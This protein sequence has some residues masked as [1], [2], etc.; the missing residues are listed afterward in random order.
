[1]R[2]RGHEPVVGRP[3]GGVAGD[4][5]NVTWICPSCGF[6]NEG[7]PRCGSCGRGEPD[8]GSRHAMLAQVMN[9]NYGTVNNVYMS[10]VEVVDVREVQAALNV[11][12]PDT[13]GVPALPPAQDIPTL[14]PAPHPVVRAIN[15]IS[16]T[17]LL[18]FIVAVVSAY[19]YV[20]L[21]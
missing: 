19:A 17:I 8:F 10:P 16:W 3:L 1:M 6:P 18:L 12:Y 20:A 4:M 9:V 11:A 21:L 14:P 13:A 5:N 7:G 15:A 2:R